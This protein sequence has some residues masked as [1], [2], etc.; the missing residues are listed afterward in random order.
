[1]HETLSSTYIPPELRPFAGSEV[2]STRRPGSGR[3]YP[4]CQLKSLFCVHSE[5]PKGPLVALDPPCYSR[6]TKAIAFG[7][8]AIPG[9]LDGRECGN[10]SG[11]LSHHR[12]TRREPLLGR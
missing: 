12:A 5:Q 3:A 4:F 1:M 8:S 10:K 6:I 7:G 11:C 9:G 2:T